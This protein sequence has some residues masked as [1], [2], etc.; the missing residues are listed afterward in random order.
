MQ[1]LFNLE[2]S[3]YNLSII[4]PIA[5]YSL[6]TLP[7]LFGIHASLITYANNFLI[8][9]LKDFASLTL[10][11]IYFFLQNCLLNSQGSRQH[12][13]VSKYFKKTLIESQITF[14]IKI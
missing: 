9:F 12:P 8:K 4:I 13:R 1:V 14:A 11:F 3:D 10:L 5:I 6:S 2:D 7:V